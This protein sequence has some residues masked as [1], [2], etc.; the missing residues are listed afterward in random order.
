M[1]RS[2]M[3]REKLTA[4]LRT[5]LQD[6][7]P[8]LPLFN[9]GTMDEMIAQN[10][11]PFRVFGSLFA[12]FA[13]IAL[14]MSAVGIYGVTAYGINQRTQEIGVRMALGASTKQVM[15]LVLRQGLMRMGV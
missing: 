5:A 6:V 2:G 3:P 15:W 9:I 7:D 13:L 14:L 12:T 11:W 1:V 10:S 8:D 4:E